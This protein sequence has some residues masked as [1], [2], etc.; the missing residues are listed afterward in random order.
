MGGS[1]FGTYQGTLDASDSMFK[2]LRAAGENRT[3]TTRRTV[4]YISGWPTPFNI[5]NNTP[6]RNRPL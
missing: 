2:P 5:P 1:Q 4:P 3:L 6:R